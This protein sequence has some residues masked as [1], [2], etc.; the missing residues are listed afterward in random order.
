[1]TR[2]AFPTGEAGYESAEIAATSLGEIVLRS[3]F[4]WAAL[5]FVLGIVAGMLVA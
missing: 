4:A 5:F 3:R 1:M 2:T